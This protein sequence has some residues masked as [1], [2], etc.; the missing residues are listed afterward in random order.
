L[1]KK[2]KKKDEADKFNNGKMR[3]EISDFEERPLPLAEQ[4][5]KSC[6]SIFPSYK[7]NYYSSFFAA[8]SE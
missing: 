2:S 3:S 5:Q 4:N 8:L 1:V 7:F 6:G